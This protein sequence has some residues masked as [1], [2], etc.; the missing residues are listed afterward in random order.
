M[1]RKAR[2]SV[3]VTVLV[4]NSACAPLQHLGQNARQVAEFA[5]L[6]TR[7]D[8]VR[9]HQRVLPPDT[10]LYVSRGLELPETARD[11]L[12]R[13]VSDA[14]HWHF[15]D[16]FTATGS[17]SRDQAV[18]SARDRQA[19]YIVY[20]AVFVWRDEE[21]TS[22]PERRRAGKPVLEAPDFPTSSD[23]A[24][25]RL[26][27]I[28]VRGNVV[29]DSSTVEVSAAWTTGGS[30]NLPRL[31]ATSMQRYASTFWMPSVDDRRFP[32]P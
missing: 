12:V 29:I 18:A 28:D 15:T 11:P 27:L 30:T 21:R 1:S 24:A 14:L 31:L 32:G 25:I 9:Q 20:P 13:A 6:V 10:R 23:R 4:V 16:V 19:D 17:E 8:I 26:S 2:L 5:G 22:V 7:H 3:M